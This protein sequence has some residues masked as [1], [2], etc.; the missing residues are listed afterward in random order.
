M[1]AMAIGSL[2]S[3]IDGLALGLERAGLGHVVWQ[4]ETDP[5]AS[6]VLAHHWPGV[7]NLDDVST[8]DWAHVEPVDVLCGGPPCQP[9][10]SAGKRK[11]RADDRWLW[12]EFARAVGALRPAVAIVENVPGLLTVDDGAGFAGILGDLATLG[13]GAMWGLLG[14]WQVGGCHRRDRLFLAAFADQSVLPAYLDGPVLVTHDGATWRSVQTTLFDPVP[15]QWPKAGVLRAGAVCMLGASPWTVGASRWRSSAPLPAP[16][17]RDGVH[18]GGQPARYRAPKWSHDLDDAVLMLPTPRTSEARG[19]GPHGEG[20]ADL[21]S[22]IALLPIP[23]VAE[24]TDRWPSERA[25]A[26]HGSGA[27]LFEVAEVLGTPTVDASILLPTP[28]VADS[29]G[30]RNSTVGRLSWDGVHVGNT[31]S[32]V[33]HAD[34][35][36]EYAPAVARWALVFGEGPPD[37]TEIGPTGARRL[38]ADFV[39]WMQGFDPGWCEGL[40]RTSAL[41]CLGNAVVPQVAQV[42]GAHVGAILGGHVAGRCRS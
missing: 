42:I 10:S 37:P 39:R 36:G 32:D 33:A 6:S 27:A 9:A 2:F 4:A 28:T 7:P 19:A 16:H 40:T 29:R 5:N 20:G 30:V 25:Q 8:V 23:T 3:G 1:L 35:F 34:R 11:G 24:S 12:P 18:G 22:A 14:A 38:S 15:I 31:L 26:L 41:K 21:R 13:Y 17:A